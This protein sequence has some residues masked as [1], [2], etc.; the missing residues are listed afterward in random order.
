MN[1][2]DLRCAIAVRATGEDL[3]G[4]DSADLERA[5]ARDSALAG[6]AAE[7]DAVVAILR[8]AAPKSDGH[9]AADVADRIARR[10]R[11]VRWGVAAAGIVLAAGTVLVLRD[12]DPE[13]PTV[14]AAASPFAEVF[15]SVLDTPPASAT[16][17]AGAPRGHGPDA[18]QA[19]SGPLVPIAARMD[20]PLLSPSGDT[21]PDGLTVARY[22]RRGAQGREFSFAWLEFATS[23]G[24]IVVIECEGGRA[25]EV[26]LAEGGAVPAGWTRVVR[27]V[28]GGNVLVAAR[29]RGEEALA[30]FAEELRPVPR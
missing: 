23:A 30:L 20:F 5:L 16:P 8:S 28:A 21:S 9:R 19:P 15:A 13:S 14:E 18:E 17:A 29:H 11:T 12:R 26:A 2:D 27:R 22:R 1:A 24:P 7:M 6:E 4:I 10:R 25:S 3:P